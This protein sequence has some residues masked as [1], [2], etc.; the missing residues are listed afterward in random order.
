MQENVYCNETCIKVLNSGVYIRGALWNA[1]LA[2]WLRLRFKS[3]RDM[4]TVSSD[5]EG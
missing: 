2:Q 1:Q 5:L 4:G 3:S